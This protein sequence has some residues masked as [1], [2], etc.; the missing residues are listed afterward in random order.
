MVPSSA[1][2]PGRS[3]TRGTTVLALCPSRLSHR[4]LRDWAETLS[5]HARRGQDHRARDRRAG[6]VGDRHRVVNTRP[7]SWPRRL[8]AAELFRTKR[9]RFLPP[10]SRGADRRG[11]IRRGGPFDGYKA[12]RRGDDPSTWPAGSSYPCSSASR[13]SCSHVRT[14][15]IFY[16]PFWLWPREP[17]SQ[18][19]AVRR[20]LD[21]ALPCGL[22]LVYA[23]WWAWY[24]G[25][26]GGAVLHVRCDSGVDAIAAPSAPDVSLFCVTIVVLAVRPG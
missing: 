19:G 26:R 11:L 13:R 23:K 8:A 10:C 9:L 20:R 25:S 18:S 6:V 4:R 7:R 3:S 17:H 2:R 14:R 16:S 24:G 21:A 1:S 22:V 5:A 12:T 15:Q